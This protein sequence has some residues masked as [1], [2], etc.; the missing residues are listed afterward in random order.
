MEDVDLGFMISATLHISVVEFI[1][2]VIKVVMIE[3]IYFG[4]NRP[5]TLTFS[6]VEQVFMVMVEVYIGLIKSTL[7]TITQL[8]VVY[9]RFS[10]MMGLVEVVMEVLDMYIK[11]PAIHPPTIVVTMVFLLV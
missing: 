9:F 10:A 4:L 11:I 8:V 3:E 7:T 1:V 5:A 6:I 2:V